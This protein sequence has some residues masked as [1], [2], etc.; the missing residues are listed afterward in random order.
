[1][2]C[3][4]Y[5]YKIGF[6]LVYDEQFWLSGNYYPNHGT[7]VKNLLLS[8]FLFWIVP[9]ILIFLYKIKQRKKNELKNIIS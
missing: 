5:Q 8:C 2:K 9:M 7:Y 1:L 6:P 4:D 3:N